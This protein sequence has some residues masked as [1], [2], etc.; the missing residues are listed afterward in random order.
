MNSTTRCN[1]LYIYHTFKNV[2]FSG[3]LDKYKVYA[4]TQEH[5]IHPDETTTT[6]IR[7][8][9]DYHLF[10]RYGN[11][12]YLDIKGL[13]DIVMTFA[14]LQKNEYWRH[15]YEISLMLTNNKR[16]IMEDL[17][18]NSNFYDPYIYEEK[19]VWSINTAYIEGDEAANT[20][21][22]VENEYNCYYKISPYDLENKRYA[23]QKE[24]DIFTRIYMS[25]HQV[26]TGIFNKKSIHYYNIVFEYCV[27]LMEK[28]LEELSAFFED[29]KNV[30]N[31]AT[32]SDKQGMNGDI[33]RVIYN[34]LVSPSSASSPSAHNKYKG[35][36][37][38]LEH[39]KNKLEIN[40]SILEA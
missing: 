26:R 30:L 16:F 12:I 11:K 9:Y 25:K 39:Y 40:R 6:Y 28:E 34:F 2:E 10:I 32:L 20:R 23:T 18:Y 36:I 13:G 38:N 3:V 22:V 4:Y 31:L 27:S 24:I 5:G 33:I 7:N 8:I 17:Q 21:V 19:R 29:K 35:I 15:Y 14:Q 37:D 1:G